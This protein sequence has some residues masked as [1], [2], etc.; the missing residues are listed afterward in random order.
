[1][2]KSIIN[3][4]VLIF[5]HVKTGLAFKSLDE[6]LV[7]H[8]SKKVPSPGTVDFTARGVLA[9]KLKDVLLCV[10]SPLLRNLLQERYQRGKVPGRK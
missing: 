10:S 6:T 2:L 8:H 5:L 7:F 1:M 3:I 9:V 4:V